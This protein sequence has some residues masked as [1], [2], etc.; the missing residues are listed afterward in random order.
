MFAL[1]G[2]V[3]LLAFILARPFEFIPK[4]R[5]IPFLHLFFAIAVFGLLLDARLGYIKLRATPQLGFV[6]ALFG[7]CLVTVTSAASDQLLSAALSLAIVLGLF[8]VLAEGVQSLR[9]LELVAGV[10]LACSLW[11]SLVCVHQAMQPYT[12]VAVEAKEGNSA[13]GRP[14]GRACTVVDTCYLDPPE[15]QALYRCEHTGLLGITSV[16]GGRV[17]YVGILHDPNEV[18][19]AVSLALPLAVAFRQRK[20]SRARTVLVLATALLTGATVVLSHSRS[21]LIVFASILCVYFLRRYR[22]KGALIASLAALP[23]WLFGARSGRNASASTDERLEIWQEGLAMVRAHPLLGVGHDQFVEHHHLTAH[24]SLL[25]AA[26]ED[27][28]LGALLSTAVV[29]VSLKIPITVLRSAHAPEAEPARVWALALLASLSGLIMGTLFLTFNYHHVSWLYFGLAGALWH[30]VKRHDPEFRVAL[31]WPDVVLV[32][33]SGVGI[34]ALI[35]VA[36]HV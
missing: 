14:D 21:G 33:A 32:V 36:A 15:P 1:P 28:L 22:L 34:L 29:L 8:L 2:V 30:S 16:D 27:G 23:L 31:G 17:R 35:F 18:A 20:R 26:A 12:C 7:W 10:V 5:D 25:L 24:N 6:G 9:G 13:M 3:A 4:L 11:I 19:L